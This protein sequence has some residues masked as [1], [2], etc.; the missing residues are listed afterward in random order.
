MPAN[1]SDLILAG[2]R[3]RNVAEHAV[4]NAEFEAVR[5]KRSKTMP[6]STST[7]SGLTGTQK[8]PRSNSAR[9]SEPVQS[10][11]RLQKDWTAPIYAFFGLNPNI[12]E[13]DGRRAHVFQ[14]ITKNCWGKGKNPREVC[15]YLDKKDAKSMSNLRKHAKTCWSVDTIDA[16]DQS[17]N[18][19]TA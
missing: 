1:E 19:T 5:Q 8:C 17:K 16:A 10:D 7:K 3:K 18:A 4:D 15:R 12:L 6:T 11:K 9:S 14:C 13:I 2:P